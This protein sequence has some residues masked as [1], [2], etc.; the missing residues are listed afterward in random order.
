[1]FL[2]LN[3]LLRSKVR[4]GKK[5]KKHYDQI[6]TASIKKANWPSQNRNIAPTEKHSRSVPIAM[7]NGGERRCRNEIRSMTSFIP[8]FAL[9][10]RIP[11]MVV[12]IRTP[13]VHS[14]ALRRSPADSHV[15]NEPHQLRRG[16]LELGNSLKDV[17]TRVASSTLHISLQDCG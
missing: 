15:I 6:R 16:A 1:M 7:F 5:V 17:R 3:E 4:N 2:F 9:Y 12:T 8:F 11:P 10:V 13:R 14:K